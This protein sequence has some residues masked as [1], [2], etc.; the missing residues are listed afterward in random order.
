MK[1]GDPRLPIVGFVAAITL[2]GLIV[3]VMIGEARLI[4]AQ[5]VVLLVLVSL[6]QSMRE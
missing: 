6:I 4:V 2:V 5:V 3:A 1:G